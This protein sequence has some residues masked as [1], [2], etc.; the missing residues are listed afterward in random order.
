MKILCKIIT[1]NIC[2]YA[3]VQ[4]HTPKVNYGLWVI[5]MYQLIFIYYEKNKC[6]LLVSD[7]GNGRR[8]AC[9]GGFPGETS[10]KEAACQH[11]T[12][13]S[14]GLE[15]S[16]RGRHGNLTAVFMPGESHGQKSLAGHTSI[17]SQRVGHNWSN[18]AHTLAQ[19][20]GCYVCMG[21]EAYE[22]ISMWSCCKP[23][24]ALAKLSRS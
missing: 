3:F 13:Q 15:K 7:A 5:I 2:H 12:Q 9:M 1:T 22:K 11:R 20:V 6:A 19:V 8:Y 16:P 17:G 14:L 23:N 4:T 21:Q 18:C 10:C 24:T